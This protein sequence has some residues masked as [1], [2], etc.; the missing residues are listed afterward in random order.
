MKYIFK[1]KLWGFCLCSH[2]TEITNRDLLSVYLIWKKK[3]QSALN[4]YSNFLYKYIKSFYFK[5]KWDFLKFMQFKVQKGHE[6][7]F[8]PL[9][10]NSVSTFIFKLIIDHDLK[11]YDVMISLI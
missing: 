1:P 2:I 10:K 11:Q 9:Y 5:S 6:L 3:P 8:A 7:C 4:K